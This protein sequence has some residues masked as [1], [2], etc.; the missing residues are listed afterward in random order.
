MASVHRPTYTAPVPPHARRVTEK[1]VEY[2]VWTDRKGQPVKA[3]VLPSG[4]CRRVVPRRWYG[5]YRDRSGKLRKTKSFG[6]RSVALDAALK[7]ERQERAVAEGRAAPDRPADGRT[8]LIDYV[9]DYAASLEGRGNTEVYCRKVRRELT[10]LIRRLGLTTPAAVNAEAV[11]DLLERERKAGDPRRPKRDRKP[12]S[13]RTRNRWTGCLKSFGRWLARARKLPNHFDGLPLVNADVDR[14]VT[15]RT[16]P[17]DQFERLLRVTRESDRV[18]LFFDG[19]ARW[20][21]YLTAAYTGL[22]IA[23]LSRLTPEAFTWDAGRPVAVYSEARLQKNKSA[24][25]IPLSPAAGSALA[26]WLA[27]KAA[28]RPLW[29]GRPTWITEASRIL[30][31]DLKAAGIPFRDAA[32]QVFDFHALRSQFGFMLAKAKVPLVVA[33]QL[34]DHSTPALTAN[35]YSRFGGELAGE[36]AKIDSLGT[37]LGTPVVETGP[38]GPPNV[39]TGTPG[40]KRPNGEKPKKRKQI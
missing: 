27:A 13:L 10:E 31:L 19:H 33:Q 28:G 14:R 40:D 25:G 24:H 6:D 35:I 15:R 20:A 7:M 4:K 16:L 12:L 34:L 29:P 30:Q 22:R 37:S 39:N 9:G 21:L 18:T 26:P 8:M 2:A 3:E 23:A 36:V 1:G 38:S 5:V 32:G 11:A 17:V